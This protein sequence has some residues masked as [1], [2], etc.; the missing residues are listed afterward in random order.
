ME[1]ILN[2]MR[3]IEDAFLIKSLFKK[4][5]GS[6]ISNALL[7]WKYNEGRGFNIGFANNEDTL[8]GH[9]G[10]VYRD[11]L[12]RGILYTVPQ[13]TDLM[14]SPSNAGGLSRGS[15]VFGSLIKQYMGELKK[16]NNP[17][18]ITFGFP[19]ARAMRAGELLG[20]FNCVD[21]IFELIFGALPKKWY[22]DRCRG[23]E[24]SKAQKEINRLWGIMQK[25][26]DNEIIGVRNF[27]YVCYRYFDHPEQTYLCYFI[28][29]WW[30]KKPFGVAFL[31]VYDLHV[32]LMDIICAKK[33]TRRVINALQENLK[34][35]GKETMNFWLTKKYAME[36]GQIAQ[37]MNETQ[38][39]ILA[40][41]LGAEQLKDMWWLTSGDTEYR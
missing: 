7:C 29:P 31:K 20:L 41:P 11:V 1:K 26:F 3:R 12:N 38:F 10:A 2:G 8:I 4:V 34:T 16:D 33:D 30:S 19:S 23:V 18:G 6:E 13:M 25:D 28:T 22:S 14:V 37:S 24:K 5:F 40:N 35:L 15:S 21:L 36:L 27:E 17:L 39:K 32:E 9:V